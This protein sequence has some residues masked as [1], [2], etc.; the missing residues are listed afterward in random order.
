[1]GNGRED[2]SCVHE[3]VGSLP[4]ALPHP[5]SAIAW[6]SR[7]LISNAPAAVSPFHDV[8]PARRIAEVGVVGAGH[9][10][11]EIIKAELLRIA[12]PGGEDL[13]VLAVHIAAKNP[14]GVG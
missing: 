11:A 7:F 1:M 4:E 12:Q 2:V 5:G 3:L 9:E 14:A 6:G 10:I 8:D 13:E